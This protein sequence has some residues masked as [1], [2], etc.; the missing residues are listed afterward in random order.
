MKIYNNININNIYDMYKSASSKAVDAKKINNI[1]K[2]EISS[3]ASK[4]NKSF[5][6]YEQI[7]EKKVQDIKEKVDSGTYYVK[8]DDIA[9]SILKGAFLDKKV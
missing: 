8:S 2:V 7:R 5:A 3:N 1:D 4:I 9:E 6:E